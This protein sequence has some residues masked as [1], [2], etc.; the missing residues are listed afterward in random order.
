MCWTVRHLWPSGARFTFNCYQ[1]WSTLM[2]RLANDMALFMLSK[3]GVM[4]G[5]LIS[6]VVYGILLLPLIK[7]LKDEIPDV[8]QPW[9]VDD[10]GAGGLS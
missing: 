9:Y 7:A 8:D 1:H 2:I 5:D 6:M 4:Q 10:A 3:E